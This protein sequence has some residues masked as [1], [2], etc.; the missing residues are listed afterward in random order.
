M[1]FLY[2]INLGEF[3]RKKL[4]LSENELKSLL[5][6]S[7]FDYPLTSGELAKWAVGPKAE[8]K[9]KPEQFV[10]EKNGLYFL[11]GR[12]G[13]V[14]KRLLKKRISKR[15]NETGSCIK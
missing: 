11:K 14:Y 4:L 9:I 15:R 8:I 10:E 2:N 1:P 7:I 6:H 5:Y 3:K 13:V 12:E